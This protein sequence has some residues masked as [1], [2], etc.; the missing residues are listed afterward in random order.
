M[1]SV[2]INNCSYVKERKE[3]DSSSYRGHK[4]FL[5][6]DWLEVVRVDCG[7]AN[8]LPF[9]IDIPLSSEIIWFGAK[10]TRIEPDDKVK[11]RKILRPLH[12]S[13]GQHLGSRKILKVF[14]ICNN[15]NRIG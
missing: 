14:M 2:K 7:V 6:E 11:L 12:L 5:S 3:E 1:Q 15:V 4:L 10:M 9:R 13:L 8:I